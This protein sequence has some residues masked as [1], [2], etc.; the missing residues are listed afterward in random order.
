MTTTPSPDVG[1]ATPLIR[2]LLEL[3]AEV[4]QCV[5]DLQEYLE[6][7]LGP[8]AQMMKV[9]I[10]QMAAAETSLGDNVQP[11]A[12]AHLGAAQ[13]NLI[14]FYTDIDRYRQAGQRVQYDSSLLNTAPPPA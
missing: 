14:K 3:T 12:Q 2:R 10:Q 8:D 11:M 6:A 7:L 9:K 4:S 1:G 13:A 5:D